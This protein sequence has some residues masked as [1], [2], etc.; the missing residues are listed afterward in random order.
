MEIREWS[1]ILFT[2]LQQL[3]VG[4]FVVFGVVHFWASRKTNPETA[5]RLANY[6]LLA[7]G[8]VLVLALLVSLLHLGNPLGAP[9]A[10]TNF[11][12]SWL[13]REIL[14][15]VLFFVA[16]GVFALTQWRGLGSR[17]VRN[18]LAVIAAVLGVALIYSMSQIYV[19]EAQPAWNSWNTVLGFFVTALLLGVLGAGAAYGASYTYLRRKD[20][21]CVDVQCALLQDALK[22]LAIAAV[23]LVGIEI[24]AAPL[25]VATLVAGP[26]AAQ[27]SAE[28][29]I[30][31]YGV[32]Y[33]L[34]LALAFIGAGLLAFLIYRA[35][36][37]RRPESVLVN[38]TYLAFAVVLVAEVLGRY[39]FY[40]TQ[41]KLGI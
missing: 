21:D 7:L 27:R 36:I 1:L 9:R 18:A 25:Y 22:G 16:G 26:E 28:L 37:L 10:V 34:R 32:I 12:T 30:G 38:L 8:P 17:T 41:Y 19:L 39:L 20:P 14:F 11:A 2:L 15:S 6:S 29:L 13:S 23:V 40:V 24:V 3:S 35:A 4:A 31:E 5:D 33:G